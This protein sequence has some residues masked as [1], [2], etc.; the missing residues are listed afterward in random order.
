MFKKILSAIFILI[1][2][3][4]CSNSSNSSNSSYSSDCITIRGGG[5]SGF[6]YY[7][8]YLQKNNITQAI[9]WKQTKKKNLFAKRWYYE[10]NATSTLSICEEGT[11]NVNI[12]FINNY[13]DPIADTFVQ[14]RCIYSGVASRN[15]L[16]Y[17]AQKTQILLLSADKEAS[18]FSLNER[19]DGVVGEF[20]VLHGKL[21]VNEQFHLSIKST[22][23]FDFISSC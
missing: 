16:L 3:L 14:P 8:G 10:P 19:I 21:L 1:A 20:V 22:N 13:Y 12:P 11:W 2:S 7:Y 4:Y 15:N 9:T 18:L 6:W 23:L 17:L 5:F